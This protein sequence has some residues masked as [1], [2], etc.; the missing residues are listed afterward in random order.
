MGSFRDWCRRSGGES[1][2]TPDGVQC[3]FEEP[4]NTYGTPS[5][6]TLSVEYVESS[7]ELVVNARVN[8]SSVRAIQE[9]DGEPEFGGG[10]IRDEDGIKFRKSTVAGK[11]RE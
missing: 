4:Y 6:E 9:L 2:K 7:G 3:D 11:Y 8:N 10:I 1:H 5:D